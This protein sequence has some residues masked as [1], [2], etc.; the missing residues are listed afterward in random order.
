MNHQKSESPADT[1]TIIQ[2]LEKQ[3]STFYQF[4]ALHLLFVT[5]NEEHPGR[6]ETK[7]SGNQPHL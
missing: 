1:Y 5:V 6:K 3:T 4:H 7:W 2:I